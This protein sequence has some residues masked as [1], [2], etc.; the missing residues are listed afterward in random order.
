MASPVSQFCFNITI[1]D[2][3]VHEGLPPEQLT[4]VPF[5]VSSPDFI[6][7]PLL[8]VTILIQDNDGVLQLQCL[9]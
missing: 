8:N 1:V 5:S 3:N 7:P 9:T 2:D 6:Q 4:L